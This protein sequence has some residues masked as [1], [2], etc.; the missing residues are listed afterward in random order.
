MDEWVSSWAP[1]QAYAGVKNRSASE[2]VYATAVEN[3]VA[4]AEGRH[5]AN[6]AFDIFKAFD[7][8]P[9]CL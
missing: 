5:V 4:I 7:Q 8:L 9:R 2:A 6:T 3:E 1:A